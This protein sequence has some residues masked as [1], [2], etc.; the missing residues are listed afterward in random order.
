[1]KATKYNPDNQ[2]VYDILMEARI[3]IYIEGQAMLKENT[4]KLG[5]NDNNCTQD[6]QL[7]KHIGQG[8][9]MMKAVRMLDD[10]IAKI[11]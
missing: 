9:G 8:Q 1:M 2:E 4:K 5:Q 11:E 7:W 3:K 6:I 10:M